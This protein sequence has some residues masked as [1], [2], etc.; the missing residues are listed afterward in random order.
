[1]AEK[2]LNTRV[3]LRYDSL[4]NWETQNPVLKKGEIA[5]ATV[6]TATGGNYNVPTV[7]MKVGD[8]T[9]DF[10]T[11]KW[12]AA[13]ASD[14]YTWAKQANLPVVRIDEE[15]KAAGNVISS[16]AWDA[17]NGRITYT[18]ASVA[19]SEGMEELTERVADIEADYATGTA[20][21]QAVETING[22]IALKLDKSEFET[23]K[24][25]N[26]QAIAD[27][28]SGA[29][30]TA[31]GALDVYKGEMTTALAGKQDVIPA[32]TYDAYGSASTAEQNA[33]DYVDGKFTNANLDQ[34][35]TEQEVKDIVDGVI[36]AAS[37]GETMESLTAL[38]DY[39][40]NHG[41][42]ATE[43]AGAITALEG[44]ADALEAKPAA[45]ILATDIEAWNAEKGAKALAETKTTTAEVKTQIEA[46]GYD[47]VAH[48][49]ELNTAMD[50]RVK[51]LEGIDHEAYKGY[52]DQAE[53]D[54]IAAAKEYSDGLAS[55]YATA[56]QGTKADSALQEITTTENG[57]LKVT[58]KNHIDIDNTVT[59]VFNCGDAS[60]NP[61][62]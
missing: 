39:I 16:V 40:E 59:F 38:V 29:E 22:A 13:Q 54:A 58:D 5:L 55:N 62:Q 50:N 61:I 28:K 37:D 20:L 4:T 41:G 10:K 15:G 1:M 19:T 14:V 44:R 17:T 9:S 6:E 2:I 30:A 3:Q 21:N 25:T 8:G 49:T 43:M 46:Y 60:G 7:L 23:F 27:A 24:T 36:A 48:V 34:Y 47:T 56:A 35:T 57:G 11:L 52:A 45:G 18:T 32:N 42:E 31:Q 26:T 51:A 33:K 53:T 12:V